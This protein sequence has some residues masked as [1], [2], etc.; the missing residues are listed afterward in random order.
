[1]APFVAGFLFA[2]ALMKRSIKKHFGDIEER[3]KQREKEDSSYSDFEEVEEETEIELPPL[4]KAEPIKKKNE[5]DD[6]FNK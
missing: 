6:L 5:Y 1:M 2:K 4:P 3:I